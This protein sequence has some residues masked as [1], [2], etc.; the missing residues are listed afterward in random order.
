MENKRILYDVCPKCN[1]LTKDGVCSVCQNRLDDRRNGNQVLQQKKTDIETGNLSEF[2]MKN[3]PVPDAVNLQKPQTQN[4]GK[5][6]AF[7]G[8]FALCALVL[9]A[10]ATRSILSSVN[11]KG[12][13]TNVRIDEFG[14]DAFT[15]SE[16]YVPSASD[17]YYVSIEN[18]VR[19][20]L[21]YQIEWK[22][23]YMENEA[24]TAIL[25]A[26]Y[27]QITG[28]FPNLETVNETIKETALYHLETYENLDMDD[29]FSRDSYEYQTVGYVTWMDEDIL[30]V[31]FM[32]ELI[33]DDFYMPMLRDIN[34]DVQSGTVMSH[35]HMIEYS[36]KLGE[37]AI[38]Q[39]KLQNSGSIEQEGWTAT[40]VR[41]KLE[42]YDGTLFFT[43]VGLELGFNYYSTES[44]F[45]GWV[46][47]TLKDYEEYL[48]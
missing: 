12:H 4:Y 24:Q 17:E 29:S 1:G 18:A 27:P 34:V 48:K 44:G 38:G 14:E 19:K 11:L 20:D 41:R 46:T 25:I 16:R 10:V 5:I 26:E 33:F 32:D 43:P 23:Y 45:Y 7:V 39:D 3:I 37:W 6:F 13:D 40:E 9:L 28:E 8:I 31:V 36:D 2:Q 47:V 42:G 30:S 35:D 22:D 21:S 15:A